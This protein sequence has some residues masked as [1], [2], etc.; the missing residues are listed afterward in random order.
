MKKWL[1]SIVG[2]FMILSLWGQPVGLNLMRMEEMDIDLPAGVGALTFVLD[3][4]AAETTLYFTT[5]NAAD[6]ANRYVY[7][8]EDPLG[9]NGGPVVTQVIEVPVYTSDD[10]STFETWGQ[11]HYLRGLAVT[12]DYIYAGGTS[13]VPGFMIARYNKSDYSLDSVYQNDSTWHPHNYF[14]LYDAGEEVSFYV[15]SDGE[16]V[17]ADDPDAIEH[18]GRY[19][20]LASQSGRAVFAVDPE[21]PAGEFV[22]GVGAPQFPRGFRPLGW[23]QTVSTV[24]R[25]MA[26]DYEAG[27]LYIAASGESAAVPEPHDMWAG[28]YGVPGS[29]YP[30]GFPAFDGPVIVRMRGY[31]PF[32]YDWGATDG[33]DTIAQIYLPPLRD[34][35]NNA[36]VMGLHLL[37]KAGDKFLFVSDYWNTR[38]NIYNLQNE[39]DQAHTYL[40]KSLTYSQPWSSITLES[41]GDDYLLISFGG[42]IHVY[43][44]DIAPTFSSSWSLFQ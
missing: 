26:Y 6:E 30:D 2:L 4:Y 10:G 25:E 3:P 16:W 13:Q 34:N 38:F 44:M 22:M 40:I 32:Q 20:L 11:W 29:L 35:Q 5:T 19:T 36:S 24:S 9:E 31:D 39:G 41:E 27:D 28:R 7:K 21:K 23:A 14:F 43:Q 17:D 12:E 18:T 33:E 1:L 37:N 8:I 42:M 15:D